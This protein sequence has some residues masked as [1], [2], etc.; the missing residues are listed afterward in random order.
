MLY[1][2]YTK[3]LGKGLGKEIQMLQ[4]ADDIVMY[5]TGDGEKEQSKRLE[6]GIEI[7]EKRLRNLNLDIEP[8]KTQFMVFAR[9]GKKKGIE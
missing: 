5:N 6:E 8:K 2:V 9:K 4:H 1:A 7:I 3:D